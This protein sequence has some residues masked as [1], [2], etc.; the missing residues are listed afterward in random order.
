MQMVSQQGASAQRSASWLAVGSLAVGA[1]ALVTSEFLPVGLLPQIAEDLGVTTGQAGLMVTMPG[2]L[3][4]VAAP[5]SIVLAGSVDRRRVLI[6][7]LALLLAS[8]LVVAT[9]GGLP[10]LIFG[11]VL[12][13][14]AVGSF[15]TIAG[16]LGP[17]LRPGAEG[18]RAS[19]LILSG[20]SIGTVAG[21]PAGALL[22]NLFG[23]RV[24]FEAGGALAAAAMLAVLINLP[25]VAPGAPGKL[26]DFPTIL[27][28]PASRIG[29]CAAV[30]VFVG[31]FA[32]YTYVA[33]FLK[34]RT[35]IEGTLLSAVLLANGAAGFFGN[36][37][38]GWL[39][40]RSPRVAVIWMGVILGGSV[41]ALA[42]FGS[43]PVAA[44]GAVIVWGFGFG[45]LPISMQSYLFATAEDRVEGMQALFTTVAQAAIGAGALVGGALV[46]HVGIDGAL[47][48]GAVA[49]L[50]TAML[51]ALWRTGSGPQPI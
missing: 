30:L 26:S 50:S 10:Q 40:A 28:R 21:V 33:P 7:L 32:A 18:I 15:W 27:R 2:F 45:L 43:S 46:D 20:V 36:V 51:M 17:R 48:V 5:L 41:L 49:A 12:L 6:G 1:F 34:D 16:S 39:A 37:I 23:W 25:S 42:L 3:A 14:V 24:A 8:N 29:L 9:A 13:G 47:L 4:A 31:Q 35:G 44:A 11:R 38:G 19:A 22:G